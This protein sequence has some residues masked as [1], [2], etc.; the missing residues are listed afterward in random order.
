MF[1]CQRNIYNEL[2]N[3]VFGIFKIEFQMK[4]MQLDMCTYEKVEQFR[5]ARETTL[6]YSPLHSS[7]NEMDS[8]TSNRWMN[9]M[10]AGMEWNAMTFTFSHTLHIYT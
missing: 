1:D 9:A 6:R 3:L 8:S 7:P 10:E 5:I 2:R 4:E